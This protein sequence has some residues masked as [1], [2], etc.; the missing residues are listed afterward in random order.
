MRWLIRRGMSEVVLTIVFIIAMARSIRSGDDCFVAGRRLPPTCAAGLKCKERARIAF[1]HLHPPFT[2]F[3]S[4]T[5]L[6]DSSSLSSHLFAAYH[7]FTPHT[8]LQHISTHHT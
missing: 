5:S 4:H 8:S 1:L 2:R 3:R 6:Y 7:H